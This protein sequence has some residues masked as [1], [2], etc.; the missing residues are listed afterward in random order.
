MMRDLCRVTNRGR[1]R[2]EWEMPWAVRAWGD[3]LAKEAKRA[4][5]QRKHTA[6]MGSAGSSL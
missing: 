6:Q 3:T 4:V 5:F 1:R 2:R